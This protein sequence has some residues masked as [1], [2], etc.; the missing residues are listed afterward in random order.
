MELWMY[1][2]M[3]VAKRVMLTRLGRYHKETLSYIR[4]NQLFGVLRANDKFSDEIMKLTALE[5]FAQYYEEGD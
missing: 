1:R 2:M 3:V 5:V 4:Q